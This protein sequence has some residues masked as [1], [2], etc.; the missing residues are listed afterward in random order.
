MNDA[1]SSARG[2]NVARDH[3]RLDNTDNGFFMAASARACIWLTLCIG[4][5]M[6]CIA[7]GC[8][9]GGGGGGIGCCC[10]GCCSVGGG[11][12]NGCGGG[13]GGG[14]CRCIICIGLAIMFAYASIWLDAMF[15]KCVISCCIVGMFGAS[16]LDM[17]LSCGG[18]TRLGPAV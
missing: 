4:F 7:V 8:G 11:G 3:E 13:G 17:L 2:A 9:C 1:W 18:H 10:I 12:Y 6:D 14:C 15:P 5:I 16:S